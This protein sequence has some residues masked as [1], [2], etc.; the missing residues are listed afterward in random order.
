MTTKIIPVKSCEDCPHCSVEWIDMDRVSRR[1]LVL[2][3]ELDSS[4]IPNWCPLE[5]AP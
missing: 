4:E 1:C 2:G 5:D 3:R